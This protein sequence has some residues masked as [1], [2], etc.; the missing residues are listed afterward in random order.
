M[1]APVSPADAE[2]NR[3]PLSGIR[4]GHSQGRGRRASWCD[5]NDPQ[6]TAGAAYDF[7][8]RRNDDGA[9]RRKLIQVVQT[10]QPKL[11][12]PVHEVVVREGWVEGG[13]L[14][15]I[16]PDRLHADAQHIPLLGKKGGAFL[17]QS[18]SVGSILLE[19]D[20]V[21][22]VRPLR[23]VCSQEKPCARRDTAVL[24]LPLA[25]ALERQQIVWV[26]C[27]L[28][29]DVDHAGGADKFLWRD[30]VHGVVWKVLARDPMDW[31]VK[32][33]AGVL[34]G[35]KR[36]PVPGGTALIVAR[37]R[38]DSERRRVVELWRQWQQRRLRT[39]GLGQIHDPQPASV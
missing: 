27:H 16:G 12:A 28:R 17:G 7:Q 2:S 34:T 9:D 36:I 15:G 22:G 39:Q 26:F 13:G 24:F 38:P 29:A 23:P 33:G 14:T 5:G 8:W 11:A 31:S 35:L 1:V 20:V 10:G 4:L 25:D 32:M 37:E 21:L 6:R 18:R 19:V 3:I 30:A